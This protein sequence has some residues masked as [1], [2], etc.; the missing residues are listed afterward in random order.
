MDFYKKEDLKFLISKKKKYLILVVACAIGIAITL[1]FGIVFSSYGNI[2]IPSIICSILNVILFFFIIFLYG[3]YRHIA[4][5]EYE[6]QSI[7]SSDKKSGKF[8]IIEVS[9]KLVTLADESQC[10]E[11]KTIHKNE[12]KILYL[13]E[14]F[15]PSLLR[16]GEEYFL[17]FCFDYIVGKK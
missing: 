8:K 12:N 6:F 10:Y 1:T 14:V 2:L 5:L 7:L 13:S 9:K 15:D 16:V 17:Y 4:H 11:V 3:K